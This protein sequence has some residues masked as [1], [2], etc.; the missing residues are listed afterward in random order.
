MLEFFISINYCCFYLV[1]LLEEICFGD[2]AHFICYVFT[3]LITF[4]RWSY[5]CILQIFP[6]YNWLDS[7]QSFFP[8]PAIFFFCFWLRFGWPFYMVFFSFS[9][10]DD[11]TV[12]VW[13]LGCKRCIA[14]LEKHFSTVTSMSVSEDGWTLL[15]AGRDKAWSSFFLPCF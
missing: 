7:L 8:L 14:T 9:G 10:S 1:K 12:R 3:S 13:D 4:C 6:C 15:S 2:V 11:T 5:M